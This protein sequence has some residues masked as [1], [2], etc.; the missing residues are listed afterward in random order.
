MNEFD[1]AQ[2]S[3]TSE[4]S[5]STWRNSNL[6]DLRFAALV[7][8]TITLIIGLAYYLSHTYVVESVLDGDTFIATRGGQRF[9]VQLAGAD[10]P[11]IHKN[12][13]Y[14]EAARTYLSE[15]IHGRK[16]WLEFL[17]GSRKQDYKFRLLCWAWV[18]GENVSY[19][20]VGK[21]YA[22]FS[23]AAESERRRILT[24]LQADAR[25]NRR[26]LWSYLSPRLENKPAAVLSP[27]GGVGT[28]K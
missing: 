26:G 15:Q 19:T 23:G 12:E 21:G 9:E 11:E 24:L 14:A 4:S 7:V 18:D 22:R 16:V 10:A 6:L 2:F 20:L 25:E 3:P 13:P 28:L 5:T 17:D 1:H 27:T 8:V